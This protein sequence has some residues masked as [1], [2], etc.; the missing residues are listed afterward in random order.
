MSQQILGA[1]ELVMRLARDS[2]TVTAE[3]RRMADVKGTASLS[4]GIPPRQRLAHAGAVAQRA[5]PAGRMTAT[6]QFLRLW[7]QTVNRESGSGRDS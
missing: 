4:R 2:E 1:A 6:R 3:G 5:P 7:G